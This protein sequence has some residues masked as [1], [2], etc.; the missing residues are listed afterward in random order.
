MNLLKSNPLDFLR[1]FPLLE[2]IQEETLQTIGQYIETAKYEK[3]EIIYQENE[4]SEYLYFLIKGIVKIGKYASDGREV[5]KHILHPMAIFGELCLTHENRRSDFAIA[6]NEEVHLLRIHIGHLRHIMRN[7]NELALRVL[8]FIGK[9]L[10]RVERRLESL[11][12]KDARERIIEFIKEVASRR[13]KRVGYETLIKHSLTQQ[14]IANITGTSRQTV[15]SVLN[16]L[17]KSNLIYFNRRSILIRDL[18]R[19]A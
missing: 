12:F 17:R 10:E 9:R 3:H 8:Q 5:I 6:M 2:G 14:D 11:I 7:N 13:G 18:E 16:E 19:L 15:T 1:H 4:D